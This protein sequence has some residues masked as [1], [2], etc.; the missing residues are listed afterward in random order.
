MV[1]WECKYVK[2]IVI[3]ALEVSK[4]QGNI[5]FS[6]NYGCYD[7]LTNIPVD[8]SLNDT[9]TISVTQIYGHC[10]SYIIHIYIVMFTEYGF[11]IATFMSKSLCG[12]YA[13]SCIR[14]MLNFL[15]LRDVLHREQL[16]NLKLAGK[17]WSEILLSSD[18]W[19]IM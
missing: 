18:L 13:F 3:V 19:K 14:I 2:I 4:H 12:G 5:N 11:C 8:T 15:R 16:K 10:D 17:V 1:L 6:S 7:N 9:Y